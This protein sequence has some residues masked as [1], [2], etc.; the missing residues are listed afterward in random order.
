MGDRVVAVLTDALKFWAIYMNSWL[1]LLP[2]VDAEYKR[3][4][5]QLQ[6]CYVLVFSENFMLCTQSKAMLMLGIFSCAC[7]LT[8]MTHTFCQ[9]TVDW[10]QMSQRNGSTHSYSSW[11]APIV[12][13]KKA[14]NS[15]LSCVDFLASFN[16]AL[17][18]C[19]YLLPILETCLLC[20]MAT[21][22]LCGDLSTS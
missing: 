2:Y 9:F 20:L 3:K 6:E 11:A 18:D 10:A 12:V 13:I 22:L 19:H 14:K 5:E 4:K 7:F 1:L 21:H 8:K 17:K 15:I 16:I